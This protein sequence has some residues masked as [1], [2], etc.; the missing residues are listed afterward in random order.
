M[1]SGLFL[2]NQ[3][4]VYLVPLYRGYPIA[5]HELPIPSQHFSITCVLYAK[6]ILPKKGL[7]QSFAFH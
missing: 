3:S 2:V 1:F 4:N 5:I 6:T 7:F